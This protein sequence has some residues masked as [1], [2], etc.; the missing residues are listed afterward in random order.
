[1]GNNVS[2]K[3]RTFS[4]PGDELSLERVLNSNSCAITDKKVNY[5]MKED[6]YNIYLEWEELDEEDQEGNDELF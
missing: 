5:N 1:M 3:V 2:I 4:L 6:L